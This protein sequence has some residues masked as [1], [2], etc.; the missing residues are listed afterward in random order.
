MNTLYAIVIRYFLVMLLLL[1]ITGVWMLLLHTSFS[2][3]SI[4]NYYVKKSLL[5]NLEV[6]TPHL[7]AMGTV[8]FT[9]THFLAL[10]CLNSSFESKVSLALFGVMLLSNLTPLGINETMAWLVWVKIGS[11]LLFLVLS[12]VIMVQVFFRTR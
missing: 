11:T 9:L 10:K 3:E 2:L 6:I 12:L 4:T 5:G 7:F 8:V 1:L